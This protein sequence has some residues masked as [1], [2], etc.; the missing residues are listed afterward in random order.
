M[1]LLLFFGHGSSTIRIFYVRQRKLILAINESLF[2]APFVH[3]YE[4]TGKGS[5]W[6]IVWVDF[7]RDSGMAWREFAVR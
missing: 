2:L 3:L 7:P 5:I 6:G 1:S 4:E